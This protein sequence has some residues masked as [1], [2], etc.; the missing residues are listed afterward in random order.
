MFYDN[1]SLKNIFISRTSLNVRFSQLIND[2][3]TFNANLVGFSVT[4]VY[5]TI[6]YNYVS[7]QEKLNHLKKIF[8]AAAFIG[9]VIVY[10]KVH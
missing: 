2:D 5:I 9:L 8:G 1:D 3:A 6:F 10:S 7:P 4:L